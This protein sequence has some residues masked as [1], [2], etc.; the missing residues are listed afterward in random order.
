MTRTEF[1]TIS[2]AD[3]VVGKIAARAAA[4]HPDAGS[5]ATTLLGHAVPGAGLLG[6]RASDLGAL[7]KTEVEVDG[8]KAFVSLTLSVRW[9]ASVAEVTRAV[10]DHVRTRVGELTG[11]SVDEVHITVSD[12][13]TDLA[14][15]ARVR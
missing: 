13:V 12:L 4:E 8:S 6:T 10:R 14:A 1:G 2:I 7:P 15:P 3:G 5:A 9:P 11:V